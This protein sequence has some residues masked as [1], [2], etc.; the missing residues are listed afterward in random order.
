[1][2]NSAIIR[3]FFLIL[4]ARF[5]KIKTVTHVHGGYHLTSLNSNIS[6]KLL[7]KFIVNNSNIVIVLSEIEKINIVNKFHCK[8]NIYVLPNCVDIKNSKE[9]EKKD[10]NILFL[11]R[12]H[13]DKGLFEIIHALSE[14]Q[15][16]KFKFN[17]CGSGP[18]EHVILN[19]C[20]SLIKDKFSYKGVVWG[21]KKID[22]INNSSVFLLPSY[23]EG[24][25][26]SL[27]ETMSMGVVPIVTDV[28][29][30]REVVVNGQNGFIIDK[31][32]PKQIAEKIRL[33]YNNK[34]LLQEMSNNARNK[35]IHN[36]NIENYF[37]KL[38]EIYE[39]I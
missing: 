39:S 9:I 16:V 28:G 20:H 22:I 8:N 32:S 34:E 27:L 24:L 12:L 29:S 1:M 30:I 35:I 38:N 33:L 36:Y 14:L 3:D 37:Q 26:I 2:A 17:L 10:F 7:I 31:K 15:D 4:L 21:D 11:G 19:K 6:I 25:P 5:R 18:L 23:Y 13:Q